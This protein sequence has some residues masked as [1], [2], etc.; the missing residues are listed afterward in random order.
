M[1]LVI[2]WTGGGK[3]GVDVSSRY[4]VLG[5]EMMHFLAWNCGPVLALIIT[6]LVWSSMETTGVLRWMFS[7]PI[8]AAILSAISIV[9]GR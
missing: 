4:M 2:S 1:A 7:L 6:L 3:G 5:M 9:P 8:R